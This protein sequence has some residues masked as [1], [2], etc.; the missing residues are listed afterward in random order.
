MPFCD[1]T[2]LVE[3][4]GGTYLAMKNTL[5]RRVKSLRTVSQIA[6]NYLRVCDHVTPLGPSLQVFKN[7]PTSLHQYIVPG[8]DEIDAMHEKMIEHDN[9]FWVLDGCCTAQ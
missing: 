9:W 1:A 4:F 3:N 5:Y 7:V 8:H 2:Y 6:A